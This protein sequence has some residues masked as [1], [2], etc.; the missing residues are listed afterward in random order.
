LARRG[1]RPTLVMTAIARELSGF[2]WAVSQAVSAPKTP[3]M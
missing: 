3:A 1:K 2:I